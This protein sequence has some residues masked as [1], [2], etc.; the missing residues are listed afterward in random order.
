MY[1]QTEAV[2]KGVTAN[3]GPNDFSG[4]HLVLL[5]NNQYMIFAASVTQQ[6]ESSAAQR[7]GTGK[8]WIP[9]KGLADTKSIIITFKPQKVN[10]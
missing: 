4:S 2:R 8:Y 10:H 3:K 9:Y 5:M 1:W 7:N 6:A